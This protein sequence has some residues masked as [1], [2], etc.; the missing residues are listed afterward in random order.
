MTKHRRKQNKPKAFA[1]KASSDADQKLM[2]AMYTEART[3]NRAQAD[4]FRE[5]LEGRYAGMAQ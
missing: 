2:A 1:F 4:I 3:R 5:M